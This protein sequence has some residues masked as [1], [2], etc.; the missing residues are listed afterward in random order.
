MKAAFAATPARIRAALLT[1]IIP[2]GLTLGLPAAAQAAE[3]HAGIP[4]IAELSGKAEVP[5]PGDPDGSG[6]FTVWVD[7][8]QS[9]ACYVLG[10]AGIAPPS[11]AHIHRGGPNEEGPHVFPL[12]KPDNMKSEG[13]AP[14]EAALADAMIADPGQFY[15][16][17]HNADYPKGAVRAQLKPR[18]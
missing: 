3:P 1:T 9:R 12:A 8:A 2:L 6:E 13:C 14:I 4:L 11:A 10:V 15:I 16:N 7:P 5:G 17:V 18:E